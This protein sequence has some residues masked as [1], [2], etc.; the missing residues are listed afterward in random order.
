[1][2]EELKAAVHLHR[3]DLHPDE[4]CGIATSRELTLLQCLRSLPFDQ[5]LA[6]ADPALRHGEPASTLRRIAA[7]GRGPGAPQVRRVA[8]ED[9][10][11]AANPFES[12]L[13]AIALDVE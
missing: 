8:V 7:S 9:D 5:A 2:T 6:A 13:R 4:V 1:V 10:G 11:D 3:R 12:V